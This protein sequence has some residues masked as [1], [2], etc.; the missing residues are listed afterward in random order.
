MMASSDCL[1]CVVSNDVADAAFPSKFLSYMCSKRSIILA[2]KK[3]NQAA[4]IA[5][6]HNTALVC[7]S[8]D[9]N[10]FLKC[11]D[12]IL[13]DSELRDSLSENSRKY[14]EKTFNVSDISKKFIKFI[15]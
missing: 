6:M 12:I 14:A 8:D 7:D 15:K 10:E 2:I 1:I 5:R 9:S 13:N 3:D 11:S 4:L